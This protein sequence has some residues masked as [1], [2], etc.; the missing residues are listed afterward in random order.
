[1]G[2]A[3]HAQRC[4]P[5]RALGND[6]G[7]L[8]SH[9]SRIPVFWPPDPPPPTASSPPFWTS[10]PPGCRNGGCGPHSHQS[11]LRGPCAQAEHRGS[12]L[13]P[14]LISPRPLSTWAPLCKEPAAAQGQ[15][16]AI[17]TLVLQFPPSLCCSDAGVESGGQGRGA[18]PRGGRA[19]PE[20]SGGPN[21]PSC[22]FRA[23]AVREGLVGC[24]PLTA[25]HWCDVARARRLE[26]DQGGA[27]SG[28]EPR[29]A[30]VTRKPVVT[31]WHTPLPTGE[32]GM[33]GI[34]HV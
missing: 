32:C 4:L 25:S 1:M 18:K 16:S 5:R 23:E 3:R 21:L 15:P 2:P 30:A 29:W 31:L 9:P 11:V 6:F 22:R 17:L 24:E 28:L 8:Q 34:R 14:R 33:C 26:G 10:G 19:C 13:W 27:G 12:C 7:V 20:P